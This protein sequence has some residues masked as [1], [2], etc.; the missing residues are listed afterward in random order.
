MKMNYRKFMSLKEA[1]NLNKISDAD[2][3]KI[4]DRYKCTEIGKYLN[5]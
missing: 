2:I 4:F 1:Y 5:N 3:L